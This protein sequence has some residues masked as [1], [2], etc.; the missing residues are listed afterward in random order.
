MTDE[1]RD[2]L[3]QKT[4]NTGLASLLAQHAA[5][6]IDLVLQN[7]QH[8]T[9]CIEASWTDAEDPPGALFVSYLHPKKR[10]DKRTLLC[11]ARPGTSLAQI[12]RDLRDAVDREYAPIA[13]PIDPENN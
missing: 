11:V 1:T 6:A 9:I 3:Q 12:V 13:G 4:F 2:D 10:D 7:R 8:L 5:T